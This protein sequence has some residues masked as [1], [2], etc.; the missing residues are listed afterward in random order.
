M[1][2]PLVPIIGG[3]AAL[4]L[5][6]QLKGTGGGGTPS[7]S[8]GRV[9]V[10]KT[11]PNADVAGDV[12]DGEQ[13]FMLDNL[14][15][16][17]DGQMGSWDATTFFR[18]MWLPAAKV[19]LSGIT[20]YQWRLASYL[21]NGGLHRRNDLE[22]LYIDYQKDLQ[23]QKDAA[24]GNAIFAQVASIIPGVG[25]L[26]SGMIN[27][28]VVQPLNNAIALEGSALANSFQ[29]LRIAVD[30]KNLDPPAQMLIAPVWKGGDANWDLSVAPWIPRGN[31][32]PVV[33]KM[34]G[35]IP[36]QY[37]SVV[38]GNFSGIFHAQRRLLAC[39]Q[40][41]Y[42]LPWVSDELLGATLRDTI[43]IRARV[44]K[45]VCT[46]SALAFPDTTFSMSKQGVYYYHAG[47]GVDI[48]GSIFPPTVEDSPLSAGGGKVYAYEGY[49]SQ[50]VGNT[51]GISGGL[52]GYTPDYGSPQATQSGDGGEF[53][54][55][56][57][58]GLAAARSTGITITPTGSIGTVAPI[59][60]SD[61]IK[62]SRRGM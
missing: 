61:Q 46:L 31:V 4:W 60:T 20:P 62:S 56:S 35:K 17:R 19:K 24:A 41:G 52:P 34:I 12:D 10:T 37:Q 55:T 39:F 6:G 53:G 29:S 48:L 14:Y 57:A 27:T 7:A 16:Y 26:I 38:R 50:L 5:M 40:Y 25:G 3:A 47:V 9:P 58:G 42:M 44:Y 33:P 21:L 2:L 18:Q 51:T 28:A 43:N 23:A 30:P 1:P 13:D 54:A 11:D 32:S 15:C 49:V 59:S 45:A 8:G 36:P 22:R